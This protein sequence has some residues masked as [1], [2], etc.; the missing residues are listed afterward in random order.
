MIMSRPLCLGQCNRC[1]RCNNNR[2]RHRYQQQQQ[3]RAALVVVGRLLLLCFFVNAMSGTASGVACEFYVGDYKTTTISTLS[4]STSSL[5]H[6][7]HSLHHS[8]SIDRNN[9]IIQLSTIHILL[10][11]VFIQFYIRLKIELASA[12]RNA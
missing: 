10:T 9:E 2:H 8:T 11:Y 12:A 6:H 3:R 1:D 5:R 7:H 4:P